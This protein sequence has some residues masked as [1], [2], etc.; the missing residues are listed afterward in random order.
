L[1]V[2]PEFRQVNLAKLRFSGLHLKK[3]KR[4]RRKRSSF[5]EDELP[6]ME[7][8]KEGNLKMEFINCKR[9]TYTQERLS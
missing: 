1:K 9:L 4:F 5:E 6:S 7:K 8:R 2:N 3:M